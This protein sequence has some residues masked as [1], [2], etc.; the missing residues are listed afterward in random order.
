MAERRAQPDPPPWHAIPAPEA[1]ARLGT[2]ALGLD[3]AEAAAR[4]ARHGPN[5]LPEPPRRGALTRF[6]DQFRNLLIYVLLGSAAISAALGHWLDAAVIL[7]VVVLNAIVGFVQEGRAEAA[8]DAIRDLLAPRA[9][10]LRAGTRQALDAAELVPG[11]IVLLEPGDRVPADIRLLE[12]RSLRA[13]EAMLTGESV[14]ASKAVAPVA[15]AA[16]LAERAPMLFSGTLVVAGQGRGVVVG[17]GAATEIGHVSTLLATV[18]T[19]KTPLLRQMD[20]FARWATLVILLVSAAAFGFAIA[21]GRDATEAFMAVVGLAVAAIPEGLPAVLT[22]TLAVGVRRM[23]ARNAIIRRLPAVETLGAVG[24]ICSDKTGTFTRNEMVAGA[25]VTQAG[26]LRVDGEGYGPAARITTPDG[27]APGEQALADLAALA[28][29][30]ALC[31]DA[32]LVQRA[33]GAWEVLGDPMEGALLALAARAGLS[34]DLPR[35]D[36]IPFDAQHRFMAT[37]HEDEDGPLLAAK[38]APEALLPRCEGDPARWE[39]AAHDLAVRGFRVLAL[40]EA[41]PGTAGDLAI[42]TLPRLTLLGLVGLLDPPRPEAIAAVAECRAAGIRVAMITGDHPGTARAIATALGLAHT[43]EPLTG[44]EMDALDADGLRRAAFTTDVFARVSPEQKL[45]LV[46]ALQEGGAVV[47]MTGDGVNDAP[48]LKRA[49]VGVAMGRKGT[50]AAKEAAHVVLADDNFASIAAAVREGRTVYANIRKVVAWTLPTN[51][52]EAL[53]VIA[54]L[55]LGLALPIAPVQILWINMVTAVALGLT[56]AFEPPEEDVMAQPPRPP[57]APLLDRLLLW[58]VALVSVLMAGIAFALDRWALA[59]GMTPQAA[60]TLVVN[61]VVAMEIGYLFAVR[62]SL[63]SGFSA[64][65]FRGTQAIWIGIGIVA[66]AQLLLTYAPPLQAAFGT[67]A[68]DVPTLAIAGAAGL[69]LLLAIEAEKAIR[70]A[71]A[72]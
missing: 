36:A 68:L 5:R 21:T 41:R 62:Q 8:L 1:L 39:K 65:G 19:L 17:T 18:E 7:A 13:E 16:P 64:E 57:G 42:A 35:H 56:L 54:A 55:L 67:A 9:T 50:E 22:V 44:V 27:G 71:S 20:R 12:A 59:A 29:I 31:N 25:V 4:R 46:S 11:D 23:A 26:A 60:S 66:V 63:R 61:A 58:R 28:R 49:D 72:R 40:A 45:R 3:E 52:G 32:A 34:G 38:G 47:A 10:V 6:L 14:P 53:V 43:A 24:T 30:G 15:A 2:G 37:L 69:L 70:R 33:D 51:G 48:A